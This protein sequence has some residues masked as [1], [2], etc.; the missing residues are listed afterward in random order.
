MGCLDAVTVT[1]CRRRFLMSVTICGGI[2]PL[3]AAA[4]HPESF[5]VPLQMH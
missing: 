3:D 2:H 1:R 5:A 4:Q